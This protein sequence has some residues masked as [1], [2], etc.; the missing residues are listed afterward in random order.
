MDEDTAIYVGTIP[1]GAFFKGGSLGTKDYEAAKKI[2][3]QDM[4]IFQSCDNPKF[5]YLL[6][7]IRDSSIIETLDISN[8]IKGLDINLLRC[9][10]LSSLYCI[11]KEIKIKGDNK[12]HPIKMIN[13][14][15]NKDTGAQ[16]YTT[17]LFLCQ[18]TPTSVMIVQ[19]FKGKYFNRG[20]LYVSSNGSIKFKTFGDPKKY[21]L[22]LGYYKCGT[23][24]FEIDSS[25][26]RFKGNRED[27]ISVDLTPF[28]N[29]FTCSSIILYNY[30]KNNI[31]LYNSFGK[32]ILVF[33]YI[34]S[35]IDPDCK[36]N[37]DI[38]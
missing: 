36:I 25:C 26:P 6:D 21:Y 1:D 4:L 5:I 15:V 29:L 8:N 35:R 20:M 13:P 24:I 11:P 22:E 19:E 14:L 23:R 34:P 3:S 37:I 10:V 31:K 9:T 32:G 12:P 7:D 33:D 17:E 27:L 18:E 2:C 30:L 16:S 28:A 38:L